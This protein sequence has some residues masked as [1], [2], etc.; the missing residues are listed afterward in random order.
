MKT[1]GWRLLAHKF[2]RGLGQ[3][4]KA[5][6]KT[7]LF[8]LAILGFFLACAFLLLFA[9][10]LVLWNVFKSRRFVKSLH[11]LV[12]QLGDSNSEKRSQAFE[13]LMAMGNEAIPLLLS[14]V[15]P[16]FAK[17]WDASSAQS[18]AIKGLAQLKAR[19]AVD[20]LVEVLEDLDITPE[21][22]AEAAWALGEIGGESAI[23]S[24]IEALTDEE[25]IKRNAAEAL[26]KLGLGELVDAILR[27][28]E[29]KD[30]EAIRKLKQF[31]A[32]RDAI[33]ELLLSLLDSRSPN[34]SSQAA[35][36]LGELGAIEA[37]P[38]LERKVKSPFTSQVVKEACREALKKL[39]F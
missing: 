21:I 6:A 17:N 37:I 28:L 11:P 23:P 13:Q 32:Y 5:I 16:M 7:V 12:R 14:V 19:E 20:H 2:Q 26:R 1:E 25:P 9:P 31:D 24:L 34:L 15:N 36:A 3:G 8:A 27:T 30:E 39:R 22:R 29:W 4:L 18:L 33:T 35:W 38:K 10:L